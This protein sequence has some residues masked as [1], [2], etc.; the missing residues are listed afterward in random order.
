MT[1]WPK[2][3][4]IW[5]WF[6]KS[7][8]QKFVCLAGQSV[9]GL[10]W[11]CCQATDNIAAIRRHPT[12]HED[13]GDPSLCHSQVV[14]PG[15]DCQWRCGPKGLP[16]E[17]VCVCVWTSNTHFNSRTKRSG[18]FWEAKAFWVRLHICVKVHWRDQKTH[19]WSN[20]T[21]TAPHEQI[22]LRHKLT[23]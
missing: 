6:L 18:F 20:T 15:T 16:G 3:L 10:P 4:V 21:A 5:H 17:C 1:I 13:K 19:F 9:R 12:G 22:I 2:T 7:N 11:M 14:C 8:R 23:L